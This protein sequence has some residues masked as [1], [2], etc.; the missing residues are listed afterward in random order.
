LRRKAVELLITAGI[1]VVLLAFIAATLL[2]IWLHVDAL[3]QFG[4]FVGIISVATY[5][6][7]AAALLWLLNIAHRQRRDVALARRAFDTASIGTHCSACDYELDPNLRRADDNCKVCPECG[8]AWRESGFSMPAWWTR[9]EGW[10]RDLR[11]ILVPLHRDKTDAQVLEAAR[12]SSPAAYRWMRNTATLLLSMI[13]F[14]TLYVAGQNP[15]S[16]VATAIF[17]VV[18]AGIMFVSV[19][20]LSHHRITLRRELSRSLANATCPHCDAALARDSLGHQHC[21]TC[22]CEW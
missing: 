6:T 11:D 3:L 15:S 16:S 2:T 19:L 7:S 22:K 17:A 5:I 8:A 14:A 21:P 9:Q 20:V 12:L 18:A 1:F 4:G 13:I 10:C